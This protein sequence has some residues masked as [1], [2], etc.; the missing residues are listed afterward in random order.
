VYAP[1]AS[2]SPELARHLLRQVAAAVVHLHARGV[3]HGDLYA[4]NILW[5]PETGDA[6]LSDMGAATVLPTADAPLARAL[7]AHEVL[8][9]GHLLTEVL[10]RVEGGDTV[11]P[12]VAACARACQAPKPADRPTPTDVLAG[13]A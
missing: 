3:V 7:R 12:N 8:A 9:L 11:L 4:H 2:F 10:A 1:G 6:L 5:H 13:L